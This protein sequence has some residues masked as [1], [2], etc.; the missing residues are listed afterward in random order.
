[1]P[2]ERAP[3]RFHSRPRAA[4]LVVSIPRHYLSPTEEEPDRRRT[5]VRDGELLIGYPAEVWATMAPSEL[6]E[7]RREEVKVGAGIVRV[8]TGPEWKARVS[9][10]GY[11]EFDEEGIPRVVPAVAVSSNRLAAQLDLRRPTG[12]E[13]PLQV[14]EVYAAIRASGISHGL[15]VRHVQAA[16][17]LFDKKGNLASPLRI[18]TGVAP[19]KR[20]DGTIEWEV[21]TSRSAGSA[22]DE[23]G[24]IDF[25][26]RQYVQ[27]VSTGQRLGIMLGAVDP[28]PG[29]GVDGVEIPT[30][31]KPVPPP[32]LGIG[33]ESKKID[34]GSTL[35]VAQFEGMLV[36]DKNGI[37][38]VVEH[39]EVPGDV[40][41]ETG[42]IDARGNV[43][44][45]G[46]IRSEFRVRTTGDL[47]V[48]GMVEAAHLDVGG[49]LVVEKGILGDE[50]AIVEVV[51]DVTV[52][53]CQNARLR[54]GGSVKILDSDTNSDIRCE[55]LLDA[56]EGRGRLRGG[57]YSARAG[58]AAREIGSEMGV[59]TSASVGGDGKTEAEIAAVRDKLTAVCARM[60]FGRRADHPVARKTIGSGREEF[61]RR[62]PKIARDLATRESALK[63]KLRRLERLC[64]GGSGHAASLTVLVAVY[65]GVE[66]TVQGKVVDVSATTTGRRFML[67]PETREVEAQLL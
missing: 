50:G 53:Y 27:N 42:N 54:C 59:P 58:I 52:R 49:N 30:K 3:S 55:G 26:E 28:E 35:L 44:I 60:R 67:D 57:R 65:Q 2:I 37:P 24:Q 61:P 16:W 40:D 19:I 32:K 29:I 6:E 64:G 39:L 14:P 31:E 38:T 56:T 25:H 45:R 4:H 17:R 66:I 62:R 18:A 33:I 12:D 9:G 22:A 20:H 34:D 15:S 5:I 8:G 13:P 51:G 41:F 1:M 10:F 7:I 43:V 21:G 63:A 23:C 36:L 48:H 47:T 11:L 46:T